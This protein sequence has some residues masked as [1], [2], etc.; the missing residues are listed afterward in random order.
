MAYE[1]VGK[2][3]ATEVVSN[4]ADDDSF[5]VPKSGRQ[6][7]DKI[8]RE[9]AKKIPQRVPG[10]NIADEILTIIG[11]L[12]DNPFV[13]SITM[14][15]GKQPIIIL[16]TED[17]ILDL[18]K[19]CL[20]EDGSVIGIDRTFNLG[21]VFVTTMCYKNRSIV[22]R[23]SNQYPI[24]L[25]PLCLHWDGEQRSYH[26]FFS[27]VR[28]KL[29][30]QNFTFGTD[31]EKAIRNSLRNNFP[32][33]NYLLC[34]K[35]LKDNIRHFLKKTGSD[36]KEREKIIHIIFSEDKDGLVFSK[37]NTEF[38]MREDN[39]SVYFDK[40]PRF[41]SYYDTFFKGKILLH[42]YKP[43]KTNLISKLWTNNNA[44][45]LNNRLKQ[46]TEWKQLKLPELVDRLSSVTKT[47]II[48]LRRALYGAGN[49]KLFGQSISFLLDNQAWHSKS[50][51]ENEKYFKKFLATPIATVAE[52]SYVH[53]S[54]GTYKCKR[55]KQTAGRKPGQ[56]KR[57]RA[58]RT[59]VIKHR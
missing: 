52:S 55:P 9:N 15:K 27:H 14:T 29:D 20:G 42:V 7:Q 54:H 13:Q 1:K 59:T 21:K 36:E 12:H 57:P 31:D 58:E 41:K 3:K 30:S 28:E 17:Q 4:M 5:V 34:T 51:T 24:F 8:Y 46:A 16:Y 44:E 39:L 56:R 45:S 26:H 23:K 47:Q 37:D 38:A 32:T 49:Y 43:L 50:V 2:K 6:L 33:A 18:K 10:N 25:G 53:S 11:E 35:H 48:D 40:Y 22:S 19:N